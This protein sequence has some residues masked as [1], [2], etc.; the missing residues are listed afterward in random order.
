[1]KSRL[2]ARKVLKKTT[3]VKTTVSPQAHTRSINAVHHHTYLIKHPHSW[4]A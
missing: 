3:T 4:R 2:Q 1:M